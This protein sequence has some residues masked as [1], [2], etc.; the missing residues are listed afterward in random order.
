VPERTLGT[1]LDSPAQQERAAGWTIWRCSFPGRA[2][3]ASKARGLVRSLLTGTPYADDAE[4]IAAELINNALLHTRS[5][6][7]GGHFTVE[8]ARRRDGIRVGVYDLGGSEPPDL[9]ELFTRPAVDDLREN[10]RGLIAIGRPAH[11]VGCE[12]DPV[13]GHLTW[14]LLASAVSSF[15]TA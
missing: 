13:S 14:A 5:G 3:Q 12:G 4:F 8:L 6:H 10:G 2:D 15:D 7:P 9:R 1:S 11:R